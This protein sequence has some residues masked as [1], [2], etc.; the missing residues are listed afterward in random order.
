MARLSK[1]NLQIRTFYDDEFYPKLFL[2]Y[3]LLKSVEILKL[4][5]LS[6]RRDGFCQ[7][8]MLHRGWVAPLNLYVGKSLHQAGATNGT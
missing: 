8:W 4:T 1:K 7:A 2:R 6:N 5:Y 3:D